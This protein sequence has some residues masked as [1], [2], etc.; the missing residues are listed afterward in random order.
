MKKIELQLW[1]YNTDR[2]YYMTRTDIDSDD[3]TTVTSD[4]R[5]SGISSLNNKSPQG[6]NLGRNFQ[7]S[8]PDSDH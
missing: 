7:R 6:R 5:G 1:K 2:L 4:I 8:P 3:I